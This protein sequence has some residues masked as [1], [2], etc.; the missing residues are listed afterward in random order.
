MGV[1]EWGRCMGFFPDG[2]CEDEAK[3]DIEQVSGR[4]RGSGAVESNGGQARSFLRRKGKENTREGNDQ[5]DVSD[6][7]GGGECV[8]KWNGRMLSVC[9]DR[10]QIFVHVTWYGIFKWQVGFLPNHQD[11]V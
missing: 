1:K 7:Q 3:I 5:E 4:R 8:P 6:E 10:V 9:G 2:I 11:T